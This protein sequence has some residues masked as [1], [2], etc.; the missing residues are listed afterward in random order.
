MTYTY[1]VSNHAK[2]RY[3]ERVMNRDNIV[4]IRKFVNDHNQDIDKWIN[5]LIAHGK[6]IYLGPLKE[7]NCVEVFING[8]WVIIT[9]PTKKVVITLYKIDFGD[10]DVND[11][12]VEKMKKKI[13]SAHIRI[14]VADATSVNKVNQYKEMISA[15]ED[16]IKY[17]KQ[18]IKNM[19][20]LNQSYKKIIENALVDVNNEKHKLQ[21]LV[22]QLI[23]KQE[24]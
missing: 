9:G 12:F 2:E 4:D 7:K 15:N 16:E 14:K 23:C 20:E 21:R 6:S 24:F 5:E 8:L 1:N 22:E 10:D 13:S 18:N 17:Q 19:E 3:A 11:L